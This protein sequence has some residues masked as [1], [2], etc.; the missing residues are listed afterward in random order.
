MPAC[1]VA[2]HSVFT[3]QR[4]VH[5]TNQFNLSSRAWPNAERL[6]VSSIH[7]NNKMDSKITCIHKTIVPTAANDPLLFARLLLSLSLLL[8]LPLHSFYFIS[9]VYFMTQAR[10]QPIEVA[11][12]THTT[13]CA[14][15]VNKICVCH[16]IFCADDAL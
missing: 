11:A 1:Y 14:F 8:L 10:R 5:Q 9:I 16:F 3:I 13:I 6:G 12:H 2:S 4:T 7:R 15:C